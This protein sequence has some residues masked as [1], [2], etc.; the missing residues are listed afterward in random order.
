MGEWTVWRLTGEPFSPEA[1]ASTPL[2][3]AVTRALKPN[4]RAQ[5]TGQTPVATSPLR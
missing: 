5:L 4:R 3:T 1:P 2:V